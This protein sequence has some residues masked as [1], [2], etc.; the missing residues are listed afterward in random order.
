MPVYRSDQGSI[1][2]NVQGASTD[3]TSW[4]YMEGGD[5]DPEV[6]QYNAGNMAPQIAVGGLRKRSAIT[7]RRAW[8][9]STFPM[10]KSLDDA[11]GDAPATVTYTPVKKTNGKVAN[12]GK[13]ITYTGIL[14]KVTRP[15]FEAASS[16]IVYL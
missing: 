5:M 6:Q 9:D 7:L 10:Y 16:S 11:S 3:S 14:G 12:V 13:P 15:N 4:D 2:L 1:V 8:S